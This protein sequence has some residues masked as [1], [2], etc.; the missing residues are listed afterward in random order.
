[1]NDLQTARF[2]YEI[3]LQAEMTDGFEVPD[4][5]SRVCFGER[6]CVRRFLGQAEHIPEFAAAV[7]RAGASA[8]LSIPSFP[9]ES[10]IDQVLEVV[11]KNI[12]DLDGL[13]CGEPGLL[14]LF[15][16]QL[17]LT[18]SGPHYDPATRRMLADTIKL[19]RLRPLPPFLSF[20]AGESPVDLELTV[21]GHLPLGATPRCHVRIFDGCQ[22]CDTP[23]L[24]ENRAGP[25][26]VSG[27]H[28]RSVCR[29]EFYE[30]LPLLE[31]L[32][33][34][35]A[36]VIETWGLEAKQVR[37]LV[38]LY[39]GEKPFEPQT[40]EICNGFYLNRFGS[41]SESERFTQY[42]PDLEQRVLRQW[43]QELT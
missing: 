27:N 2:D 24:I 12:G 1:M 28:Y 13:L 3:A 19:D 43:R 21:A 41:E 37:D 17:P 39:R 40:G 22:A 38:Q 25:L 15:R 36:L 26:Y 4:G 8:V 29:A 16:G 30:G 33:A 10:E 32:P 9:R 5:V 31:K 23:L 7:H 42:F 35:K 14:G 18:Y 11:E 6:F 34:I 20:F